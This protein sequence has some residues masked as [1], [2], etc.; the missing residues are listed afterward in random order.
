MLGEL[1]VLDADDV[2]GNSGRGAAVAGEATVGD[3]ATG[4]KAEGLPQSAG[5]PPTIYP[6]GKCAANELGAAPKG[7][8]FSLYVRAYWP[9]TPVIDGSWTP[10][11]VLE[12]RLTRKQ[13]PIEQGSRRPWR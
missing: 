11:A 3:D 7:A 12:C 1:A 5:A 2:S 13:H 6:P 8:D 9:K 10:P 4:G